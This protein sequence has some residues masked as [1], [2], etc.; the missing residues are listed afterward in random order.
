MDMKTTFNKLYHEYARLLDPNSAAFCKRVFYQDQSVYVRRLKAIGFEGLSKVLDAGCGYGQWTQAMARLNR[1]VTA[2]DT[3]SERLMVLAE[4]N[5][6]LGL[7]NVRVRW[8]GVDNMPYARE[9]FDGVF[10]YSVIFSTPWKRTLREF[11]RVLRKGGKL[12]FNFN[13]IG[14]YFNLWKNNPNTAVNYNPRENAALAFMNTIQYSKYDK[15]PEKGQIILSREECQDELK[16]IGFRKVICKGEGKINISGKRLKIVSFFKDS[17][18]SL[19][20]IFEIL[21]IK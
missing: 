13:Q 21:A 9:T 5:K 12:Y 15:A 17:Y 11:Y 3:G 10:S 14:W 18:E 2:I 16:S 4:L 19:P 1:K 8:A 20:G 6:R 7:K